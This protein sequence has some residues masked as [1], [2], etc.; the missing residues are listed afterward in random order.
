MKILKL[1]N[2]GWKVIKSNKRFCLFPLFLIFIDFYAGTLPSSIF[3]DNSLLSKDELTDRCI[4]RIYF[5][6]GYDSNNSEFSSMVEYL[7]KNGLFKYYENRTP[8]YFDYYKNYLK[9]GLTTNEINNLPNAISSFATNFYEEIIR[10]NQVPIRVDIVAHSLGGLIVREML[11]LYKDRLLFFNISINTVITL[12]T[13][14]HG[15]KLSTHPLREPVTVFI[16]DDWDTKVIDSISPSSS[17]IKTLNQNSDLYMNSIHWYL[18][19]GVSSHPLCYLSKRVVFDGVPCD[20]FVDW[21]S[22]LAMGIE[23]HSA[24]KVI[25]DCDHSTLLRHK[26]H[27]V[28]KFIHSWLSSNF[29]RYIESSSKQIFE[30]ERM[31]GT[32]TIETFRTYQVNFDTIPSVIS[33]ICCPRNPLARTYRL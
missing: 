31:E 3:F 8:Q 30:K 18:I 20:G 17:F 11:R 15:S 7:S 22:A 6:H 25:V 12:G 4:S 21:P 26:D 23:I 5:I 29:R 1:N 13:P 19:A 2:R 28:D 10:D 14:H 33:P 16:G 27:K 32:N 9:L 24:T